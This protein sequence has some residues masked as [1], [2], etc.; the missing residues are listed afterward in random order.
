M[1]D[2]TLTEYLDYIESDGHLEIWQEYPSLYMAVGHAVEAAR[3]VANP[4]Y[5]AMLRLLW[6]EFYS[7]M[8]GNPTDL[9]EAWDYNREWSEIQMV[10]LPE[11][12]WNA[13]LGVT[14]DDRPVSGEPGSVVAAIID[15]PEDE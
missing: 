9:D 6:E 2:L 5:K 8:E 12:L 4:N 15:P 13:A 3:R 14:E 10:G 7:E 1:S 11:R